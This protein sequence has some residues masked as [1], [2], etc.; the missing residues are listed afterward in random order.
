MSEETTMPTLPPDP[1]D[2]ESLRLDQTFTE[3]AAVKKLLTT[4][5][6]RKPNRQDFVRVHPDPAWRATPVGI[7]ELKEDRETYLVTPIMA[8][9]LRDEVSSATLFTA[10]TRQGTLFLWPVR[11]PA[12]D[13]RKNEWH[14]SAHEGA[15]LAMSKW[16]RVG[17]NMNLGAYEFATA[18]NGLA[19]PAWPDITF[20]EVLKIA[21]RDR[22]IDNP[23]HPVIKRLRGLC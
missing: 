7:L 16:I 20:N 12:A 21:F 3:G 1:F 23:D 8:V 13:G 10:I 19:D 18:L 15:E 4:I 14:R 6:V 9:E 2:P 17:A 11:L 5:P 22:I